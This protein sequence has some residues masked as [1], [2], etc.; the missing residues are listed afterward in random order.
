MQKT[1]IIYLRLLR[2]RCYVHT[3]SMSPSMVSVTTVGV[4]LPLSPL[5][6]ATYRPG[7][8]VEYNPDDYVS[9]NVGVEHRIAPV[10]LLCACTFTATE[11]QIAPMFR[12][13]FLTPASLV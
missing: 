10:V 11:R 9:Q 3:P 6:S 5:F 8:M 13:R 4:V 7:V 1:V 12:S 2:S